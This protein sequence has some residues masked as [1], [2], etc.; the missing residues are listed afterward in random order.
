MEPFVI[1]YPVS[2]AEVGPDGTGSYRYRYN[3]HLSQHRYHNAASAR[4]DAARVQR[5]TEDGYLVP[6]SRRSPGVN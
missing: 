1:L 5:V 3:G 2:P 6:E 4:F